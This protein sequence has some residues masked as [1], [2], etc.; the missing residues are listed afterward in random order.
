VYDLIHLAAQIRHFS[1]FTNKYKK[2]NRSV[3]K[4]IHE[5]RKL[6]QSSYTRKKQI[7][8]NPETTIVM[9]KDISSAFGYSG[10][11]NGISSSDSLFETSFFMKIMLSG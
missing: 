2:N 7:S 9:Y 6:N 1:S 10:T 4:D 3:N 8:F 5:S 11:A